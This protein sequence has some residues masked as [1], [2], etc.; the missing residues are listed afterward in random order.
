MATQSASRNS[1]GHIYHKAFQLK[2]WWWEA[3]EPQVFEISDI[4]QSADVAIIGAGYCGLSAALELSKHG[5]S[6]VVFDA[7]QPGIVDKYIQPQPM[8]F[9]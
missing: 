1:S 6:S 9:R 8:T 2:P 3:Y 7:E 5:K 4:P